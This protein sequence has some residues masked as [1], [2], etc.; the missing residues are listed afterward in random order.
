MAKFTELDDA[1]QEEV[2][3]YA[4]GIV[5]NEDLFR[6]LLQTHGREMGGDFN[7]LDSMDNVY[8]SMAEEIQANPDIFAS[9]VRETQK[10]GL[11]RKDKE[12]NKKTGELAR[13]LYAKYG[14]R[15]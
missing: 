10:A 11:D 15:S 5:D 14:G 2:S 1:L 8:S 12:F 9:I 13:R 4:K 7:M 6:E 3:G